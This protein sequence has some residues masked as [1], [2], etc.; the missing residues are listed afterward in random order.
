VRAHESIVRALERVDR[1]LSIRFNPTAGSAGLWEVLEFG[2]QTGRHHHVFYWCWSDADR[3]TYRPLP[4]SADALIAKLM[5]IDW[6]RHGIRSGAAGHRE[7]MRQRSDEMSETRRKWVEQNDRWW[8]DRAAAY[9][10][11]MRPRMERIQRR[12]VLGGASRRDAVAER[13]DILKDVYGDRMPFA[14]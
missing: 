9:S 2:M 3:R 5:K 13:M 7:A 11:A 8:R 12:F 1:R 6:G 4:D 14:S 10:N